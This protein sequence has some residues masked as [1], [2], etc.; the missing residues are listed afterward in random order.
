MSAELEEV[1]AQIIEL[2]TH[3]G[4]S[5]RA[6]WMAERLRTLRDAQAT[7]DAREFVA[8]ELHGVVLGMGG[9]MDMVL[10]PDDDIG[11]SSVQARDQLDGLADRL[12]DLTR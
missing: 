8:T 10:R 1:T 4:H 5:D 9:L 7:P 12:Y 11:I 6:D 2:L 3:T